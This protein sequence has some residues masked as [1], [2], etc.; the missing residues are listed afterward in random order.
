MRAEGMKAG[1]LLYRCR[2]C[3]AVEAGAH[4]PDLSTVL[5]VIVVGVQA[6]QELVDGLARLHSTH[7]C[8]GGAIGVADLIGGRFD[9][10]EGQG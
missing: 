5:T 10:E 9:G 4:V 2:R 6:P 1:T 3:D 8:G 7:L